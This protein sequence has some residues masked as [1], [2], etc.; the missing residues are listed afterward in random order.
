[1][2][3]K[4]TQ[5]NGFFVSKTFTL[6]ESKLI[7]SE[8]TYSKRRQWEIPL[9]R[10]GYD[11]YYEAENTFVGKIA[12][13]VCFIIPLF[14]IHPYIKGELEIQ[15]VF[16]IFGCFWFLVLM[17]VL[18]VNQD[19][20]ILIGGQVNVSFYRNKP[21]EEAVSNFIDEIVT[22]SKEYIKKEYLKFEDYSSKEEYLNLLKNLKSRNIL[23]NSEYSLLKEEAEKRFL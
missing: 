11:K 23:S 4:L 17:A 22:A 8:K 5:K 18:R 14:T 12:T 1:M 2:I 6:N 16:I 3:K 10:I 9:D 21:N 15:P 13:L 20:I 7:I 19:D